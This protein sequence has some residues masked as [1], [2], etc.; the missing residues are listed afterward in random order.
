MGDYDVPVDGEGEVITVD[1]AFFKAHSEFFSRRYDA[2]Q[3]ST[4]VF[5][6]EVA[7]ANVCAVSSNGP[8]PSLRRPR[9]G[10][11]RL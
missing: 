2:G 8:L 4:Y 1:A 9:M 5:Y 11:L 7:K 3:A 6:Y 10:G